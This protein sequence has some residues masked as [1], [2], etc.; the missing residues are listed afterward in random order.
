MLQASEPPFAVK[1]EMVTTERQELPLSRACEVMDVTRSGYYRSLQPRGDKDQAVRQAV[2]DITDANPEYGYRR[3]VPELE[4]RGYQVNRKRVLR[5][6]RETGRLCRL[7]RKRSA[8]KTTDS[9]HD[10]PV[11]RDLARERVLTGP[12]QLWVSDISYLRLAGGGFVYLA[13]VMDAWSRRIVGFSVLVVLDVRLALKALEQALSD[14]EVAPGLIHHSD[15]GCQYAAQEYVERVESAGLVMSMGRRGQPRDNAKAESF[16]A[17]LKCEHVYRT[18]YEDVADA[19]AQVSAYVAWYNERRRHSSL[20]YRSPAAYEA[21]TPGASW[22]SGGGLGLAEPPNLRGFGLGAPGCPGSAG[23]P[24]D[25]ALP[26]GRGS[27]P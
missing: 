8:P 16:F 15:R 18:E 3:I 19:R 1:R 20:G 22:I 13:V 7:R 17:T 21:Q 27:P 2:A 24:T 26:E 10:L 11:P 12:N 9:D 4:E 6:T 14:R 5:L 23:H 25:L